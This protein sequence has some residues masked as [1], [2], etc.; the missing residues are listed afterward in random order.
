MWSF[1]KKPRERSQGAIGYFGLEEWWLAT[2]SEAERRYIE[3]V[4]RPFGDPNP[5]PLTEGQILSTTQT[6]AGLL[7][8]LATWC[9]RANDRHIAHR[10]LAKAEALAGSEVL[11]RHFTYQGMIQT[12]YPDRDRDPQALPNAVRACE[13]QIALATK[14]AK[15]FKKA[16][17]GAPLPQ[18]VGFTQLAIV[19]EK[20]GNYAQA[21]QLSRD[22]MKHGWAGDWEKRIARCEAKLRT[23]KYPGT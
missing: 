6:A 3:S 10:L 23:K 13:K 16:Y 21:I 2:F 8:G 17:R 1:R 7:N 22:A 18:H 9:K 5:R 20:D 19:G 12:Y 14:A 4:Y 15:A 11:D